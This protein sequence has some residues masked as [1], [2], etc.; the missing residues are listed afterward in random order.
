MNAE[1][2]EDFDG[3]EE[4]SIVFDDR[5][6]MVK[7]TL[8]CLY[9][10]PDY[11]FALLHGVADFNKQLW[12]DFIQHVLESSFSNMPCIPSVQPNSSIHSNDNANRMFGNA[13]GS[14]MNIHTKTFFTR[15][16]CKYN[17]LQINELLLIANNYTFSLRI[18]IKD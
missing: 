1:A 4:K 3:S 13:N 14:R 9:N 7:K 11:D 6:K 2:N 12:K 8:A 5:G 18:Q 17:K 15:F 10:H 16:F